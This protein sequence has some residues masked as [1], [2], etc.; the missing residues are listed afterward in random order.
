LNLVGL[1][2]DHGRCCNESDGY[3]RKRAYIDFLN[4]L[5]FVPGPASNIQLIASKCNDP[6]R[7]I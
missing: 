6:Y 7:A 5:H 2:E 3:H 4:N 1:R